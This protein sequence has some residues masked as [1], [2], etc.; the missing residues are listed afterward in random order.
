MSKSVALKTK[1]SFFTGSCLLFF[2]GSCCLPKKF[3]QKRRDIMKDSISLA[4]E[5]QTYLVGCSSCNL[6][7]LGKTP[8]KEIFWEISLAILDLNQEK[9]STQELFDHGILITHGF[10]PECLADSSSGESIRARQAKRGEFPC[11]GTARH[12]YCDQR[13]CKY[14]PLCVWDE[15]LHPQKEAYYSCLYE[16]MTTQKPPAS[17]ILRV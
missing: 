10:C 2:L 1:D 17:V 9:P 15:N 13:D 11:F 5:Y 12:G 3:T 7:W 8:P 16:R 6:I 14:R 4:R